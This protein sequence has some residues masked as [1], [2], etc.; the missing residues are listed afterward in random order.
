MNINDLAPARI[1]IAG[2]WHGRLEFAADAVRQAKRAGAD[3][4]VHL[5]DFG[6]QFE[7][8]YLYTLGLV[9]QDTP[10]FFVDGNH[11]NFDVLHRHPL[12]ADG[13]RTL[14]QHITHLPRGFSWTWH[15]HRWLALGGAHSVDRAHREPG[16]SWWPEERLTR[17]ETARAVRAGK[18]DVMVCHDSPAGVPTPSSYP[19]GT[20]PAEDEAIAAEHRTRVRE[21]VD[22]MK[23]SLLFHGH[24]HTRYEAELDGTRVV[25]LAHDRSSLAENLILL[26]ARTLETTA[27]AV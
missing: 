11:E 24:F 9:L 1:A 15:G 25:G 6:Y 26:D 20:F 18:V 27:L 21:V 19:P 14:T 4:I 3:A 10:L 17:E 22:A 2:D 8:S 13:T 23:P 12:A 16:V 5:G 7:F